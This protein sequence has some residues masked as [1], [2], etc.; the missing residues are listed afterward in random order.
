MLKEIHQGN[1]AKLQSMVNLKI[2]FWKWSQI[3]GQLKHAK[4]SVLALL[5]ADTT[6]ITLKGKLAFEQV[7]NQN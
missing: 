3:L 2:T 5:I 4:P 6:L 7:H 1:N